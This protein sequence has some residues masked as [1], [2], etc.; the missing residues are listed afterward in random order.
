[1]T[2]MQSP[3][4]FMDSLCAC[5][6]YSYLYLVDDPPMI[7]DGEGEVEAAGCLLLDATHGLVLVILPPLLNNP[8]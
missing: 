7:V 6:S 3:L 2:V 5:T 8:C 4:L 1:M